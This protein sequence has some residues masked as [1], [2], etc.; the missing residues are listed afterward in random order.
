MDPL[1]AL[2]PVGCISFRYYSVFD[3]PLDAILIVS[4]VVLFVISF[5]SSMYVFSSCTIISCTIPM[6]S[7]LVVFIDQLLSVMLLVAHTSVAVDASR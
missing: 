6:V 5:F 1:P 3:M 4:V 7:V 2:H